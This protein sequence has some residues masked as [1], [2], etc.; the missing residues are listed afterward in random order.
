M[1]TLLIQDVEQDKSLYRYKANEANISTTIILY[2]SDGP[3]H[4]EHINREKEHHILVTPDLQLS[5][6][7]EFECL[8]QYL[9]N[10][11]QGTA[12]KRSF[13]N[14]LTPEVSL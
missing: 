6:L 9:H 10:F 3:S 7:T 1:L 14:Q 8:R 5:D 11:G 12:V 13:L 4:L 2:F